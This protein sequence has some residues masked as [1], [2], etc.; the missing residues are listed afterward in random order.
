[1]NIEVIKDIERFRSLKDEWDGLLDNSSADN[2]FLTW[3]WLYTWWSVFGKEDD[4]FILLYRDGSEA[5]QGILP[6]YIKK[7]RILNIIFIKEL[8]FIG[9][10]ASVSSEYL[11]F[12]SLPNLENEYFW[13]P[14]QDSPAIA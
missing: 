1:M 9:Y 6:L 3:E 5:L 2:I 12:I 10:G 4:L 11:N 13:F 14:F 7:K 8:R